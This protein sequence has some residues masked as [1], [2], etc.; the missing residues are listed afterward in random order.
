MVLEGQARGRACLK[1]W[2][3]ALKMLEKYF[4]KV[5]SGCNGVPLLI[6]LFKMYTDI[7]NSL[8]H[9]YFTI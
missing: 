9:V 8:L 4:R 2:V 7:I 5:G 6:S 3:G 1:K